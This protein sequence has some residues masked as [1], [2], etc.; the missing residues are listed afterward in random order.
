MEIIAIKKTIIREKI[1]FFSFFFADNETPYK[2]VRKLQ[3]LNNYLKFTLYREFQ[4][5]ISQ[6]QL[7]ICYIHAFQIPFRRL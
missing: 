7:D 2:V 4:A 1:P 3:F 5:F 6:G